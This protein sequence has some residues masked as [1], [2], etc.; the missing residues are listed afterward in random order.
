MH[1]RLD[2][3]PVGP[4]QPER[5]TGM[6]IDFDGRDM[7]ETRLLQAQ[8]LTAGTGADLHTGQLRQH[9]DP[10]SDHL[11]STTGESTEH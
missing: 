2:H 9:A 1:V 7:R 6:G 4:V 3:I 8:R 10:L 5:L 11:A